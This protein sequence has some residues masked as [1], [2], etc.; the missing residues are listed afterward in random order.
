MSQH[1]KLPRILHTL[2]GR[3]VLGEL[4]IHMALI[5]IL[6][7]SIVS[8]VKEG[9]QTRFIDQVRTDSRLFAALISNE[10]APDKIKELL[11]EVSE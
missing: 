5:P 9:Y 3:M 11:D 7:V 4:L 8:I 1:T 10:E 6:F 2:T